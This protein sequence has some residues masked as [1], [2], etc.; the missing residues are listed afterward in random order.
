MIF[1]ILV[2]YAHVP[3]FYQVNV[4]PPICAGQPGFYRIFLGFW[5]VSVYGSGLPFLMFIFSFLTTHHIKHRRVVPC[6]IIQLN[7]DGR[8]STSTKDKNLLRMAL[9]QRLCIG[10][11]TSLFSVSQLYVSLTTNQINDSL[12]S[13][14]ENLF[15]VLGGLISTCGHSAAFYLYTITSKMFRQHLP[16]P[17][18]R[19]V[20]S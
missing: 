2:A 17:C 16:L 18:R 15:L 3:T 4:I 13:A 7:Q 5:H 1:I 14:K 10:L 11:T 19:H 9:V 6:T 8:N 20:Q 12:Q